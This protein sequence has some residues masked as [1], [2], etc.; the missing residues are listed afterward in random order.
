MAQSYV[1]QQSAGFQNHIKNIAIVGA[2]GQVGKFVVEELLKKNSFKITAI[3]RE[4]STNEPVPGVHVAKINY[5]DPSTIVNAL[6]GQDALIITMNVR[7]PPEQHAVLTKAAAE[8]GVPW[9]LPNEFGGD[10][11]EE[12][13]NDIFIGP[14]KRK[15]REL[16]ESLGK[17][18]WIGVSCSFW[19]EY[20]LAGPGLFGIHM[21]KREVT[22]FDDGLQRINTSTWAQTGRGIAELLSLPILPQDEN[23]K[24]TTLSSYR[25]RFFFVSS[26][27]LNQREMFEAVKRATGTADADWTINSVNS[28]ERFEESRK[29]AL[30]GDHLAFGHTMYTRCFFPGENVALFEVTH[31]LDNDKLGLPKEDLEEATKYSVKL[32]E[33]QYMEK[34][35]GKA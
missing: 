29:K 6:K 17:S 27:T 14:P 35:F 30:A 22:F 7:A 4:D 15:E 2:G 21:N 26:F 13:G 3:T 16:I 31:G 23:D 24:S 8:A 5:A 18:S 19:Y 20:S 12:V 25:N 34:K 33:E 9:I 10:F 28:K 11:T 1:S 32:A